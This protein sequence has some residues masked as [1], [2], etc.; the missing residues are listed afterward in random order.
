MTTASPMPSFLFT[1]PSLT[2]KITG[3]GTGI[4]L[5]TTHA[6]ARAGASRI[7]ILGRRLQMLDV[8][9]SSNPNPDTCTIV[10][11]ECDVTCTPSLLA[12]A[13]RIKSESS[14]RGVDLL[15]ANAGIMG[16]KPEGGVGEGIS[17]GEFRE[18]MSGI[19]REE[20][21]R[22]FEVKTTGVLYTALAFLELLDEA[23]KWRAKGG[24]GRGYEP[25]LPRSSVIVT[26][27][28]AGLSRLR[29]ASLAYNTSKAAMMHLVKMLATCAV[30]PTDLLGPILEQG[31]ANKEGAF[32]KRFIPAERAGTEEEIA[33]T[34][35]YMASKAGGYLNGSI[36][37]VDGGRLGV[38]S[39]SY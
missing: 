17:V 3:G 12:A 20:V 30:F 18:R 36:I 8:A 28:I 10:P 16:P 1:T 2:A 22:T 11:V 39:S 25:G 38:L 13:A 24:D 27:S 21:G 33:G 5:A 31:K 26:G 15:V 19:E 23:N 34:V 7:Y 4:G 29:G 32:D 14:D 6:L 9:A 37:L 35:L